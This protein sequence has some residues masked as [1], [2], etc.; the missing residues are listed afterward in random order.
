MNM[1][2]MADPDPGDS[3]VQHEVELAMLDRLGELH[4]DWQ[5]VIWK[6]EAAD[7]GLSSIWQ[8]AQPDAT[9]KTSS[10]KIIIVECYARVG[11]LKAGHRRKLAL[12]ALK[13][14]ALRHSLPNVQ[15]IRFILV[16][17][18]ELKSQLQGDGWFPIAIRLAAEVFPV[19]LLEDERRRLNEATALQA[20]GQARVR[21]V[22]KDRRA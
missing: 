4:P 17:P 5:R 6:S 2:Q 14:L 15:H 7:L 18:E 20:K 16:V 22:G 12:D 21:R 8:N 19:A 1:L 11:E 13:L 3:A 10:D 9:W